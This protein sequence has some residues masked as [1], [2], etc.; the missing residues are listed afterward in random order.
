MLDVEGAFVRRFVP[1]LKHMPA[2]YV[3][4]PWT[5]PP[6][7]QAGAAKCLVGDTKPPKPLFGQASKSLAAL[8][9]AASPQVQGQLASEC[10]LRLGALAPRRLRMAPDCRRLPFYKYHTHLCHSRAISA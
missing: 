8:G 4:A 1:E 10:R 9:L 3:Y 2:K 5:T 7:L 6:A